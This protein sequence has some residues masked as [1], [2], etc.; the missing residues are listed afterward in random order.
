MCA[1]DSH[2]SPGLSC[3]LRLRTAAA[4]AIKSSWAAAAAGRAAA[5]AV[6]C[7]REDMIWREG[8]DAGTDVVDGGGRYGW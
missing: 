7:S 6:A 2:M 8:C 5:R 1:A 3:T 4:A